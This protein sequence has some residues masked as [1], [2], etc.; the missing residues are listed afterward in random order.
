MNEKTNNVTKHRL[1]KHALEYPMLETE[2]VFKY[3]FQSALGCEH[4][5]TDE[6]KALESIKREYERE[7]ENISLQ[8]H[9]ISEKLDGEY[10]RVHL[11]ALSSGLSAKTLARL[12]C[13]SAKKELLGKAQIEEKLS[14]ATELIKNGDIPI[15]EKE[16][17]EKLSKWR[18]EG[19]PPVHHSDTFRE[20]YRP[21]YRVIANKYAALLNLF[22]RIDTLLEKGALTVAIEGGSASGKS[23]LSDILA[24]IY[25]CNVIHMDD[26]FLRPEQRTPERFLEVGG[27][28]DRERF[29]QEVLP[30]LMKNETVHYRPFDCSKLALGERRTLAPK[31]LTVVEG[32]YSM[33]PAFDKY[34]GLAVFL[35]ISP[36][37]QRKRILKRSPTLADRFFN[38]WIPLENRYFDLTGT[39][40]KCSEIIE[41]EQSGIE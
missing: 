40:S 41:A 38:E 6:D 26:F 30:P 11:S 33:H 25:D 2:D 1:R 5:V 36:E 37:L 27:N 16:F 4:L 28:V 20:L 35:N 24:K 22:I 8:K 12:F 31:R 21:A 23:T 18:D 3:V 13:L 14:V 7:Y 10:S 34:Y 9:G 17:E 39:A 19:Y 15:A 32:V 29:A